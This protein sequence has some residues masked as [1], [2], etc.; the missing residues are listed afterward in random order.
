MEPDALANVVRESLS[1][2]TDE[3][4]SLL[5][6]Q[7]VTDLSRSRLHV[8]A[9]LFMLGIPATVPDELSPSDIAHLVR[10][11]RINKPQLMDL[12]AHPIAAQVQSS[13]GDLD[14]DARPAIAA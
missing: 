11:V 12:V 7:L 8:G 9:C 3:R 10:Y 6:R 4:M 5:R 13:P 14:L 1:R 2:L